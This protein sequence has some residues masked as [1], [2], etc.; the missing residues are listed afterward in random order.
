MAKRIVVA[1]NN[2]G[3]LVEVLG[4]ALDAIGEAMNAGITMG[5]ISPET[6]QSGR[7]LLADIEKESHA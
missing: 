6:F 7:A 1:V 2:H 5:G 3:R 4:V